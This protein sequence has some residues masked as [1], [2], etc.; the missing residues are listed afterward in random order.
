[1]SDSS[2][3]PDDD[4][5]ISMFIEM[6]ETVL[7]VDP[8]MSPSD[9]I[10][11]RTGEDTADGKTPEIYMHST[12][13]KLQALDSATLEGW[14][15]EIEAFLKKGLSE[16]GY[17][18][19]EGA[20][21]FEV[22]NEVTWRGK[23]RIKTRNG[24]RVLRK[25]RKTNRE[26]KFIDTPMYIF[27]DDGPD[28][29]RL[30]A[31]GL[32]YLREIRKMIEAGNIKQAVFHAINLGVVKTHAAIKLEGWDRYAESGLRHSRNTKRG[33][34]SR[35]ERTRRKRRQL[36]AE[37]EAYSRDNPDARIDEIAH[38]VYENTRV[39]NESAEGHEQRY[40]FDTILDIIRGKYDH[41]L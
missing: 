18:V 36:K 6:V 7:E 19:D 35:K 17:P 3:P 38:H 8:K 5:E 1:M 12:P 16:A 30:L 25:G 29:L 4:D 32:H 28:A 41:L 37:G 15:L 39:F 31:E 21:D 11:I 34:L 27:W 22:L 33:S 9:R 10:E 23:K 2:D 20:I 13:E 14:L 24:L 40:A 26:T